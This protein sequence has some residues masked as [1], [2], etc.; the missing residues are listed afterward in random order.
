[1]IMQIFR[2]NYTVID[3]D[4]ISSYNI[5]LSPHSLHREL[6]YLSSSSFHNYHSRTD[7]TNFINQC[8][9]TSDWRPYYEKYG[10][11]YP[12]GMND[13]DLFCG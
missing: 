3:Q 11:W 5:N 1:M 7:H 4:Y 6:S 2:N 12:N 10:A 13:I 8:I 9:K